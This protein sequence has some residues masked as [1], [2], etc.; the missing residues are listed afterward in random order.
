VV[1]I[2]RVNVGKSALAINNIAGFLRQGKTTLLIENEDLVDDVKRRIGCRLCNR[3]LDWAEA[4]PEQYESIAMSRGLGRLWIPDP[5]PTSLKEVDRIA[6]LLKPDV[7]VVNQLRHLATDKAAVADGTGAIDRV[8][9]SLRALG[10]RRRILMVLVGAA[11]EGERDREGLAIEKTVLEM[12][13]S[14]GSRTGV[15]GIADAL[16]TIG[17]NEI[18]KNQGKVVVH[19]AKNKRGGAEPTIYCHVNLETCVFKEV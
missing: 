1:I 5:V 18:L 11:L 12:S 19:L 3:G 9:Q 16:I 17:T 6:A 14:Y 7:I 13:D 10:K 2:G 8:A 15:P 4:N